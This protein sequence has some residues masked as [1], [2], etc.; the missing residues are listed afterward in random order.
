M[1]IDK[2]DFFFGTDF[3]V[4]VSCGN[5]SSVDLGSRR[6]TMMDCFGALP[7]FS[8]DGGVDTLDSEAEAFR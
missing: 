4:V 2:G 8:V 5:R 6:C 1:V 7:V 3:G